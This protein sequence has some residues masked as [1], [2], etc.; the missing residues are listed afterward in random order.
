MRCFAGEVPAVSLSE[1]ALLEVAERLTRSAG[2][3]QPAAVERLAGGRNNRVYRVVV[4][5]GP[6]LFLKS[7][8]R[9]PR[10]TRHR[11]A[12]EWGFLTYAWG[13]GIRSIP[14]P[15][16]ADW[17]AH[18]GLYSFVMGRK[19]RPGDICAAHID[20]AADFI[21]AV[22][23]P[24]RHADVLPPGSEACFSLAQHLETIGRR[25]GN[26]GTLHPGVPHR[27]DVERFVRSALA[28]LWH[29]VKS[30]IERESG[31]L[32]LSPE[33]ELAGEDTVISPSDF[34]F[35]NALVQD[36]GR[37]IFTDFEYAGRDDPAKLVCDFSCQPELPI[38]P[39]HF[40]R[41]ADRI[42][43]GL[44]LGP[45]H[46]LRC[47]LLLDAYRIK[48]ICI[49]LNDFRLVGATQ[50]AFAGGDPWAQRCEAQLRKAESK[51]A[52]VSI[53]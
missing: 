1:T 22:N 15:L 50:R 25:V 48:W 13:K 27:D 45:A 29:E 5:D 46:A 11:L 23:A 3:P 49:I 4:A 36:D 9:D 41:F 20:V 38:P 16:A 35:Q 21:L 42:M 8:F 10:D 52:E 33:D 18:V 37:I 24:P 26:L 19:L 28:P 12:A 2:R 6:P 31:R 32:G 34:G 44:G 14:E 7:Y 40:G 43:G 17:Q 30:R 51:I 39:D 53:A 47:R